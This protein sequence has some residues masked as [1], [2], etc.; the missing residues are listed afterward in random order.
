MCLV[1]IA[2]THY[3]LQVRLTVEDLRGAAS[4]SS[5]KLDLA[6]WPTYAIERLP[7]LGASA[8]SNRHTWQRRLVAPP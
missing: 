6:Y 4:V 7:R 2:P 5:L 8:D 1:C 3:N